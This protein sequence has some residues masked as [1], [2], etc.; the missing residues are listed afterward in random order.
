[1]KRLPLGTQSWLDG[2]WQK[3]PF[4]LRN[5]LPQLASIADLACLIDLA[6]RSD[7]DSRLVM[8]RGKAWRVEHG[9]FRRRDFTRLPP[10]R[11]WVVK[12]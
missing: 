11:P 12:P 6:C 10:T 4:L 8:G 2:Y 5:A 7:V 9:P 3:K 1:M